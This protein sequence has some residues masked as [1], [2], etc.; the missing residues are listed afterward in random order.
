[1]SVM[2]RLIGTALLVLL[3]G[4]AG[5]PQDGHH[6]DEVELERFMG[7]WFV[8][9]HIPL[10]PEKEA[11][12]AVESYRLDEDRV[13]I[14]FQFRKGAADG[15]LKTYTPVAFVADHPSNAVWRMQFLWPF[16]ADFRVV[17]LDPDYQITIIGRS[18]R[19]Y[20]WIMAREPQMSAEQLGE[21]VAFLEQEGY[22][23]ASLRQVPQQ[24]D[25]QAGY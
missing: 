22:D 24:W 11:W 15:P 19:D 5:I 12:N 17:W 16:K 9:A 2:K 8:I 1:M 21:L 25:G 3:A 14:N 23:T 10:S 20:A 18:K 4:C 6:V 7:D 13:H